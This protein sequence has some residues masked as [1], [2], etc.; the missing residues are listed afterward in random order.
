MSNNSCDNLGHV[1]WRPGHGQQLAGDLHPRAGQ[2]PALHR[3]AARHGGPRL[4]AG[5]PGGQTLPP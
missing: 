5:L 4:H 1:H 2:E 3:L